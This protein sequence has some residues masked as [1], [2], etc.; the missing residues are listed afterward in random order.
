MAQSPKPTAQ[1]A[2]QSATLDLSSDAT[3]IAAENEDLKAQNALLMARLSAIDAE[4]ATLRARPKAAEPNQ[5]ARNEDGDPI[6]DEERPYGVV[7]GDHAA[8][9]VQDGHQ[10]GRDKR[11][12]SDEPKGSPKPFNPRLVGIVKPRVV[13]AA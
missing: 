3:E 8:A 1:N 13:Q 7:T 5:G 10:F 4:L 9:Y 6:F 12:L 2:P 11:Y